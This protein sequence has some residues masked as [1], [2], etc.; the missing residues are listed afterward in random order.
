MIQKL[1]KKE[2]WEGRLNTLILKY[3]NLPFVRGENCCFVFLSDCY[4]AL[5]GESPLSE[6][7]GNIPS[8][9]KKA[10]A[11]YKK[12]AGMKSFEKAFQWLEPVESYMFAQRGDLGFFIDEEDGSEI[13][14]VVA[15]NG[16]DFLYRIENKNNIVSKKLGK[17][18]RLWRAL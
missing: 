7:K 18:F 17:G 6:W 14:G 1:Q 9:R 8:D 11:L 15:M 16:R 12:N 10:L 4:E 3:Y 5:A 2:G 13:L